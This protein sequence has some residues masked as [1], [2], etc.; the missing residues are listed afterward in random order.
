MA[1]T[2]ITNGT[3]IAIYKDVA[4]TLTKIANATSNDFTITKDMIETTNKDSAGAKEFIAGEYG[5]TMSVEGMFEEDA[6]VGSSISWKEILTDLLAGTS[7]T[8][9][10]TSNVSGDLKLSGSAFFNELNLTAP[11][12]DVATFT[13]SI[14]GTG[15]LTVGTI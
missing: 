6:S 11:K 12:N 5:Y 9:V 10:M 15:A 8:I 14:Q 3:L 7:V 13:A 2:G 1:S 4:G